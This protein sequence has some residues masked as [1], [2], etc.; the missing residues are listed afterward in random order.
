MLKRFVDLDEKDREIIDA[1]LTSGNIID[2][3]ISCI[4]GNYGLCTDCRSF[5]IIQT[6]FSIVYS[7]CER[8]EIRLD[9]KNKITNC[10]GYSKRLEMSLWD[11]KELA[12]II[13]NKE[14]VGF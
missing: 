12:T 1:E 10:S 6:D 8:F 4:V 11:M 14:I 7:C 5:G 9:L 3:S 2:N 13:E